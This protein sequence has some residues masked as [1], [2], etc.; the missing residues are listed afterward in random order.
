MSRHKN[1]TIAA[2]TVAILERGSYTVPSGIQVDVSANL[3]T[4]VA[5]TRL[6]TPEELDQEIAHITASPAFP[7]ET[8]LE[9]TNETSLEA[10]RRLVGA[11]DDP[12][13]CLNFASAK[14]PGGGFLNGAQA[15]E[16]SL[17]RS[18]GLY[19]TLRAQPQFYAYHRSHA[20]LLYSDHMIYSP[21]VPVFRDDDGALL[22]VPYLLSFLTS[23]DPNAGAINNREERQM[24]PQTL[25]TRSAKILAV[26]YRHNYRR[27]IL[28]AWGCGVFKNAPEVVART[29]H[30]HLSPDGLF[31]SR[32]EQI[33]FAVYDRGAGAPSFNAFKRAFGA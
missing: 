3:Q 15:Q 19:P 23:P 13:F 31:Y 27:L 2:D 5:H 7:F 9:V 17:A 22:D 28:G 26:A 11:A 4:A 25:Q 10:A 14:N 8:R 29:F 33:V 32:F 24:I 21:A 18:S 12:V 30:A 1:A 16:E 6:Y 20:S